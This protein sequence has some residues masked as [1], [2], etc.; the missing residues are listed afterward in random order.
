VTLTDYVIDLALIGVVVLQL[1]GRRLTA[2]NLLL[3]VAL[4]GWA[5]ASYL[6]TIPTSGND[7][8]LIVACAAV[9]VALGTGAGLSTR[10]GPGPDG[11][12]IAK[13]GAAAALLWVLGVGLRFAFQLRHPR[14]GGDDQ[15]L[16]RAPLHQRPGVG[17]GPGA[18]GH[19]GGSGPH[20]GLGR[21]LVPP[22]A[23]CP[24]RSGDDGSW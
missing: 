24:G 10:V 14:W 21:A 9:G 6:H 7:L 19:R 23:R 3:P 11:S 12:L 2:R 20:R 17:G 22:V 8:V 18:D 16:L 15:P 13:A 5:A 4:V 1:R